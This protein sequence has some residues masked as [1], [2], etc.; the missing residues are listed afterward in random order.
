MAS[1]S[2]DL[3]EYKRQFEVVFN[4][5]FG[6]SRRFAKDIDQI[7]CRNLARIKDFEAHETEEDKQIDIEGIDR[8]LSVNTSVGVR[9]RRLPYIRYKD[10][11]I[12]TKEFGSPPYPKYYFYGY[13]DD[14]TTG[15]AYYILFD[16][17]QF[18]KLAKSG[19]IK[20]K[21][22]KNEQH[23]KVYFLA[24][25]IPEIMAKCRIVDHNGERPSNLEDFTVRS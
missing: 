25:P 20:G 1:D 3:D 13:G 23:S 4:D 19:K 11:T 6:F 18:I 15:I 10:F 7:L 12:D 21:L 2:F 5:D 9:I 17:E 22:Q 24:F 8:R 16:F 14:E